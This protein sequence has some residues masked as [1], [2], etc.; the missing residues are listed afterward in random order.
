MKS[1]K[2]KIFLVVCFVLCAVLLSVAVYLVYSRQMTVPFLYRLKAGNNYTIVIA[3]THNPLEIDVDSMHPLVWEN[4]P[5][6]PLCKFMAD[7]F[8]IREGDDFYIFYE[9]MPSKL[10]STWGDVAVLHSRDLQHWERIGVA[11]DEPFHLSFPNV[12]KYNDEWY[13][14]PETGAIHEVRIYKSIDFPLKW[15]YDHTLFKD[16][17]MADAAII[18][19]HDV[20]YLLYSSS[21]GFRLCY[22][23]NLY[24]EWHEH[25]AS[26]IRIEDGKQETRP[27]GNFLEYN[28]SLYYVVQRHDGG[29]GTSV[30]AYQIDSLSPSVFEEHRLPNNPVLDKHGDTYAKD[31]MHQLSCIYLPEKD[32][33]FCVMDGNC[34][35]TKAEWGWDWRNLP[36]F[37]IR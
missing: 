3:Y 25:L 32:L 18:Q 23:E 14:I 31:G 27:A 35:S 6:H 11:L 1:R 12:F 7:P 24:S 15:E 34:I 5:Q 2:L 36:K 33:Y 21:Q 16:D 22:A 37:R 30:V 29:Y 13:M 20:W 19:W 26:P 17:Y 8:I 9:E 10:N 28:D 4:F